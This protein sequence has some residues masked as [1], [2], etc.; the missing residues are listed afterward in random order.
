MLGANSLLLRSAARALRAVKTDGGARASEPDSGPTATNA[1]QDERSITTMRTTRT[2]MLSLLAVFALGAVA[3]TTASAV[4]TP[5]GPVW[6]HGASKTYLAAGEKLTTKSKQNSGTSGVFKLKTALLVI[7]CKTESDTGELI[8]GNPGTDKSEVTFKECAPEGKTYLE[9]SAA[10]NQATPGVIGPFKVN[11]LLGYPLGKKEGTAEAYDQLFPTPSETEFT[12][13]TLAN[14]TGCGALKNVSVKVVAK[15]TKVTEP[16]FEAK[17]GVI[18]K[19]GKIEEPETTEKFKATVSEEVATAGGLEF[20]NPAIKE[21]EV[22]NPTTK[23]FE[24]VKCEL[25][26]VT[27]IGNAKAE[28]IGVALV[29]T[30]PAEPFG[31]EI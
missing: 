24:V 17:C 1:P 8:G 20:P 9:C 26:A 15:G 25:E 21:E 12:S 11:T 7:N 27:S 10:T 13:F 5:G 30:V 6:I 18:A 4:V 19:V 2:L 3:A 28:E 16:K 29:E 22:W 31:W 14:V 23:K